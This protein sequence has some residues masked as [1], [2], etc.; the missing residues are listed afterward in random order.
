MIT[1]ALIYLLYGALQ[2]LI[3]P[4]LLLDDAELAPEFSES[5]TT[6][7]TYTAGL[8]QFIPIDT[9]QQM[10]VLLV[11]IF[12]FVFIYKVIMWV[13]KKIPTIN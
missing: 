9:I 3:S 11:Y 6:A 10:L 13:V 12:G 1:N 5:L 2:L 8:N 7:G 4:I